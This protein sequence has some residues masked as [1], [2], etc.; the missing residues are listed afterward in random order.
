MTS[1]KETPKKFLEKTKKQANSYIKY[2]GL[3]IQMALI[4]T[5][6]ALGAVQIDKYASTKPIFTVI[7]SLAGVALSLY[8]FIKQIIIEN[9]QEGE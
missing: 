2:S 6:C 9:N 1:K 5:F 4:I 8:V 7:G 3:G